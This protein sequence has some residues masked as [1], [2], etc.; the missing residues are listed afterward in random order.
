MSIIWNIIFKYVKQY[1]SEQQLKDIL[2]YY[3]VNV[4]FALPNAKQ[5]I[6]LIK[7]IIII[8]YFIIK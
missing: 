7:H 2:S 3:K 1:L 6:K 4:I 8:Y 5:I